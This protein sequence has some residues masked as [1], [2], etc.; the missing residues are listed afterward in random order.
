MTYIYD[1]RVNVETFWP[2]LC[3]PHHVTK[4]LH[5]RQQR[6]AILCFLILLSVTQ[7]VKAQIGAADTALQ[8]LPAKWD[9]QNC[10]DYAIRNNITINTFRLSQRSAEQDLLQARAANQ[11]NLLGTASEGI[12]F[13]K[14]PN[15]T[16][17]Y[18]GRK[19]TESGSYGVNSA[20][21]LYQGGYIRNNV[22]E[23]QLVT[24]TAG[25]DILQQENDLT[26][27]VTQG[28]LNILLARENIIYLQDLVNTSSE[29]VKQAQQ[30]YD[31]GAIALKDLVQLQAQYANDK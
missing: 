16:G 25:L 9:L 26:L 8:N 12:T 13:Q 22:R 23:K 31:A 19:V 10:L 24:E 28:F 6:L 20:V 1:Q 5:M 2:A 4:P 14:Q 3:S 30:K 7:M 21:T 27:S 15:G 18:G 17:G 29:Q 11:P